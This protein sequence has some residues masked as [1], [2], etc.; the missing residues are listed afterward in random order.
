MNVSV[1]DFVEEYTPK[2][3]HLKGFQRLINDLKIT[4]KSS[5]PGRAAIDN[6]LTGKSILSHHYDPPTEQPIA[7][8]FKEYAVRNTVFVGGYYDD[9]R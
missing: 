2:L 6:D 3:Q 5:N 8:A 1:T 9:A 7:K 4:K